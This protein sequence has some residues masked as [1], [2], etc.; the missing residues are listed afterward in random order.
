[1]KSNRKLNMFQKISNTFNSNNNLNNNGDYDLLE[2]LPIL[3]II[4]F[5]ISSSLKVIA[6]ILNYLIYLLWNFLWNNRISKRSF[7][8]CKSKDYYSKGEKPPQCLI[9]NNLGIPSY[10]KLQVKIKK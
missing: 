8:N 10:I 6:I 4:L 7:I 1:M 9:D 2:S 5:K 3:T